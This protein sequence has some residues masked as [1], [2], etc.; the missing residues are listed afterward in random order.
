M[1]PAKMILGIEI[2]RERAKGLLHLSQE[3]YIRK[4]LE[5][6]RIKE[7][8]LIA[9]PLTE[10]ISL[11]KIMSPQTKVEAQKIE[12]VPYASR[13][14]SLIYTMMYYRSDLAHTVSQVNRFMA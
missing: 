14:K 10:H 2:L 11:S 6:F 9:L 7:A 3:G 13:V 4:I 8:K 12:R 5:R 1:R